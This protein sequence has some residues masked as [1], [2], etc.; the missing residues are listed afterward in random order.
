MNKAIKLG[1]NMCLVL[2]GGENKLLFFKSQNESPITQQD[3]FENPGNSTIS[4][5]FDIGVTIFPET[6]NIKLGLNCQNS[7]DRDEKYDSIIKDISK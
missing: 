1:D 2:L 3:R 4:T 7:S 5:T 6:Y